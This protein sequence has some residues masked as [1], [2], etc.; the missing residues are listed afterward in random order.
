VEDALDR[1]SFAPV[2]TRLPLALVAAGGVL[3][4]AVVL[5]VIFAH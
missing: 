4:A 2:G 5:I 1:G 3:G